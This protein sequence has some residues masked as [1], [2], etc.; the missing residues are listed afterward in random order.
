VYGN[1]GRE[2]CFHKDKG[3]KICEVEPARCREGD[4]VLGR[5][6]IFCDKIPGW[7]KVVWFSIS[8]HAQPVHFYAF[9]TYTK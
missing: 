7:F 4:E 3:T 1:A 6:G 8:M 5:V 9:P 2:F